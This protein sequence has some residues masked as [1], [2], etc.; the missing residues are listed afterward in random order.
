MNYIKNQTTIIQES[1]DYLKEKN[2]L[3]DT[4]IG[5][6][7]R[8]VSVEGPAHQFSKIYYVFDYLSKIQSI[9]GIKEV[10]NSV[11]YQAGI[12][13]ALGLTQQDFDL[14]LK[15]DLERLVN[16]WGITRKSGTK[17]IGSIAFK[18]TQSKNVI[19]PKS[20]IISTASTPAVRYQTIQEYV[21]LLDEY[22][23]SSG[24][25]YKEIAIES[26][27][28]GTS[29]NK[30]AKSIILLENSI[31]GVSVVINFN[32]VT[33]GMDNETDLEL[34][35]RAKDSWI[36]R[37][38]ATKDGYK[39]LLEQQEGVIDILV[40]GPI[41]PL[42]K[43]ASEGS[44]DL[45]VLHS[46]SLVN[47]TYSIAYRGFDMVLP[48]QPVKSIIS[49]I[50][51]KTYVE[52]TDFIL[53]KDINEFQGSYRGQD[54]IKWIIGQEPVINEMLV[55]SYSYDL[56]II[57]F[58]NVIDLDENKI[59]TADVIVK[60]ANKVNVNIKL[61][62]TGFPGYSNNDLEISLSDTLTTFFTDKLL[63]ESID[64]SDVIAEIN[65]VEGVDRI[66]TQ[67]FEIGRNNLL[68]KLSEVSQISIADN[69]YARLNEITFVY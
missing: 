14:R 8:D 25:Y 59:I 47:A 66:N 27:K 23:Q 50:G 69:E 28:V 36:G 54:K 31:D 48:L 44:I 7:V 40:V 6:V 53:E 11:E 42:M 10:L 9:D 33:G 32:A 39:K 4:N 21:G 19:I 43:R 34:L 13:N 58:Q 61:N 62:Y 22:E 68:Q 1:V 46:E 3:I 35:D 24:L 57:N 16:N 65:N 52:N 60:K 17:A 55:I 51:S 20:T 49:V 26:V 2:S 29:S 45:Y 63:G 15:Q 5:K 12:A 67:V 56:K 30:I 64:V 41:N 38:L 18:G 37:N